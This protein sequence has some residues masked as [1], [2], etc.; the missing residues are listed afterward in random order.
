MTVGLFEP[1]TKK[2]RNFRN[3]HKTIAQQSLWGYIG[4][5]VYLI[6]NYLVVTSYW[7]FLIYSQLSNK[8]DVPSIQIAVIDTWIESTFYSRQIKF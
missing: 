2:Y 4:G 6:V 5:G 1:K 8:L 3:T 7:S